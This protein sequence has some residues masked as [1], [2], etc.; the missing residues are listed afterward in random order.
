MNSKLRF[1]PLRDMGVDP[2]TDRRHILLVFEV[3]GTPRVLSPY[4]FVGRHVCT[5]A[6]SIYWMIGAIFV[7]FNQLSLVKIIEI[8]AT[9]CKILRL[10]C[11][12]FNFGTC[13]GA[14]SAPPDPVAGFKGP[15]S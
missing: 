7:K 10:K 3:K 8:V 13:A 14:Y 2:W 1:F 9:R 4:F 15:T 5:N 12:K 11:T 6:N